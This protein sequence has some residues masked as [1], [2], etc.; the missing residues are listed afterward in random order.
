[1]KTV[2]K[3]DKLLNGA[4]RVSIGSKHKR[5]MKD[6]H[7]LTRDNQQHQ[8]DDKDQKHCDQPTISNACSGLKPRANRF[9]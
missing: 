5:G 6:W 8:Y 7:W 4:I 1:M 3:P 2:Q 9:D